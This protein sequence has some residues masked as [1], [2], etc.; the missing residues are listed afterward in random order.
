MADSAPSRPQSLFQQ[1]TRSKANIPLSLALRCSCRIKSL[2]ATP[3]LWNHRGVRIR[4]AGS[5]PLH[6]QELGQVPPG[7]HPKVVFDATD[8]TFASPLDL[9]GTAAWASRLNYDGTPVEFAL[10]S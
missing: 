10:S 5:Q 8:M 9:A 4:L 2:N 6:A 1:A 3:L 7:E